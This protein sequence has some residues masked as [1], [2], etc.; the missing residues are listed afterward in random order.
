[1]G[2]GRGLKG[3]RGGKARGQGKEAPLEAWPYAKTGKPWLVK[4]PLLKSPTFWRNG[5]SAF[6][7]FSNV[8]FRFQS[9]GFRPFVSRPFS[10]ALLYSLIICSRQLNILSGRNLSK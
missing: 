4:F 5:V 8:P 10:K 9:L 1:M 2:G 7:H 6:F 3:Y